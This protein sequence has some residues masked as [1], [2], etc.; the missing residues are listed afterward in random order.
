MSKRPDMPKKRT[1]AITLAPDAYDALVRQAAESQLNISGYID[2]FVMQRE[3]ERKSA[4]AGKA[5]ETKQ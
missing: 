5:S 2:R 1:F 3:W 4:E